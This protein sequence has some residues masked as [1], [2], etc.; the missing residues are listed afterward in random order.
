MSPNFYP[1]AQRTD[2]TIFDRCPTQ[3]AEVIHQAAPKCD[4]STDY[5]F[6][7]IDVR[8][9]S[10]HS[11]YCDFQMARKHGILLSLLY[12]QTKSLNRIFTNP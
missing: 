7:R 4:Y 11:K 10:H 9:C 8:Y 3:V 5:K 1:S 6:H 2:R 12:L